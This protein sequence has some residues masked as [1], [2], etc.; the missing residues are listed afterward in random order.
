[1][2][3]A[4]VNV[5]RHAGAATALVRCAA[6]LPAP[7]DAVLESIVVD[8]Y[9]IVAIVPRDLPTDAPG[10]DTVR[11]A[12]ADAIYEKEGVPPKKSKSFDNQRIFEVCG[13]TIDGDVGTVRATINLLLRTSLLTLRVLAD[14]RATSGS[15]D[16][17]VGLWGYSFLYNRAAYSVFCNVY[18]ESRDVPPG[19]VFMPSLKGRAELEIALAF[20]PL[21]SSDVRAPV[22]TQIW[23][24][25]AS[26]TK[27]A[28]V[29]SVL[30][31]QAVNTLWRLRCRK[32]NPV[33]MKSMEETMAERL[34]GGGSEVA[35][36]ILG[37]PKA[38][39]V[40]EDKLLEE[41]GNWATAIVAALQWE[42][43]MCYSVPREVHINRKEA[44]PIATLIR[45]LS[46]S[47]LTQN[48][49]SLVFVDSAVN[50]YIWAKGRSKS[51][52][53]NRCL[54]A[55]CPELLM[56]GIRLGDFHVRTK[57]NPADDPTRFAPLRGVQ[58]SPRAGSILSKLIQGTVLTDREVDDLIS[59]PPFLP[60]DLFEKGEGPVV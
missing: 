37:L 26:D 24:T 35:R 57:F 38:A 12:M 60:N 36:E 1:M 50:M 10:A 33:E 51:E 19:E 55:V 13:A 20:A 31:Q 46:R 14:G 9:G 40:E 48:S 52:L 17:I 34:L 11:M 28:I 5:L 25:D 4:H 3:V 49:R 39:P 7:P 21:L 47:P 44:Q 16:A 54:S 32:G 45:K 59:A 27:A 18:R 6:A 8:D 15:W 30:P 29:T 2:C 42:Y 41:P 58:Y 22:S 53:M 23:A 56:G 43:V